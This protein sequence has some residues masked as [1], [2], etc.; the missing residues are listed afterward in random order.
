[1]SFFPLI[2]LA[3]GA[4]LLLIN[5]I[6]SFAFSSPVI[7]VII[8]ISQVILTG[9]HH[10]D[11]LAD[12]F[13]GMVS[14]KNRKQRLTIMSDNKVGAFGLT[15]LV[16]LF[17]LKF[18][19]LNTNPMVVQTLLVMPL[20]SR[21]MMVSAM[22]TAPAARKSGMG[23]AFK[24]GAT[25]Q[26]FLAATVITAI[27]SGIILG[28]Q[29]LMLLLLVWIAASL[30]ALFFRWRFGGLTGDNYGAINE[31]TEVLTIL[32]IVVVFRFFK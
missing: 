22:F 26:R 1:M 18:A 29:G 16:L 4:V 5:Y 24:Q 9:S 7:F 30:I 32:L 6:F 3:L 23:F 20:M 17:L 2:G 8:I 12:T 25:W 15:A 19:A 10:V 13:D 27:I 21:W 31:I 14:G 11:G 28:W